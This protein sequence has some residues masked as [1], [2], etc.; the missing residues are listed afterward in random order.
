MTL[1]V[2][3]KVQNVTP[4]GSNYITLEFIISAWEFHENQNWSLF[5]WY[6]DL[7]LDTKGIKIEQIIPAANYD[8]NYFNADLS[9][10]LTSV[11]GLGFTGN[12]FASID[13]DGFYVASIIARIDQLPSIDN[14]LSIK[15]HPVSTRINQSGKISLET[16]ASSKQ[17]YPETKPSP[18][19]DLAA[20]IGTINEKI[21]HPLLEPLIILSQAFNH[22]STISG[23]LSKTGL[24]DSTI[25]GTISATD[26]EGLT[27]ASI[28]SIASG[29]NPTNGTASIAAATGKWTYTPNLNFNGSDSFSVLITDDK[30]G[31]T[32]QLINL[33]ITA[34][35]DPAFISGDLSKTGLEDSTITGSISATD[36]EGLTDGSIYSIASDKNPA[37]GTA[38]ITAAT[39][40]WTYTP[41]LNFNGSDSFSALVTDDLGAATEQLINLTI[42]SL[43]DP[44]LI[45]GDVSKTGLEDST[46]TGSISA[47]DPEGLTNGSIYSIA[48][49]KNPT[50]G[51]ASITAATG[52]WTYTP[53]SN[54]NGS[55]SFSVLITDDLGA[56]TDQLINLTITAIDDP[57]LISGD[58]S[59]TSPEDSVIT[60]SISA[61]DP[62]GLTDGSIYSI[63]SNKNPTNGTASITAATGK[64]T[65]TPNLNFNGSDS[66]T[67][68]ITDD[69]GG[70]T[71][72]LINLTISA[73]DDTAL[74]SGDL[75]KTSPEDSVIT[76]TLSATDPEGLTDASIFSIAS[77]KNP[78]NGAASIAAA[79]GKWT[80]TPN[81]NFNGS[82]LFSVLITDDK[83]GSTE[84]QI[85]LTITDSSTKLN[86]APT[87]R[88]TVRGNLKP[89][90][91]LTIS[92]STIKDGDNSN[93]YKPAFEYNWET[94][95]DGIN[96]SK[97]NTADALDNNNTYTLTAAEV[98]KQIRAIASYTD[99]YGTFESISSEA[100]SKLTT[101]QISDEL[102]GSS[103]DFN[104]DG[105]VDS[106]DSILMMRHMM[107]TFPGDSIK[108]DMPGKFDLTVIQRKLTNAFSDIS[109]DGSLRLD[110]DGDKRISAF[111][112][113]MMITQHI[114]K[115]GISD[116]PWMPPGFNPPAG[117]PAQMQEHLK[118]LIGF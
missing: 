59:K 93:G 111:R 116:S 58:L 86:I 47:T 49:N 64:W 32:E 112:D 16:V 118:D 69:K 101:H 75:R 12:P 54:F 87:G 10:D 113:G 84:Q 11:S 53:N 23:D 44:A 14:P 92:D 9:R 56:A 51:T 26:P 46:I 60:G 68:L 52:K 55:D 67:V 17:L 27:D 36:P 70:S 108:R 38:S 20:K 65:Y 62:E 102:N 117:F 4:T 104:G 110:I 103:L 80:Y 35:D 72:Q 85:N 115:Q 91:I 43:D 98:N 79:T 22:Q 105:K 6:A 28:F 61:T 73:I 2:S 95:I 71:E 29:K 34:I 13:P 7:E 96:W 33:T 100:S 90:S 41:N 81:L 19:G 24:E 40:K 48:S 42:T 30:G 114:H 50:N 21:N 88:P 18:T 25:T 83:G 82:D 76:G 1:N 77:G 57:A 31:S 99:G 5:S 66:F 39:G 3:V 89:G 63:A 15:I 8:N 78:T 45:S 106:F 94:S 74:I 97:L 109:F 107:G 37:N